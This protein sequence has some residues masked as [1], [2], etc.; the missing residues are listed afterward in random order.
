MT[1][2]DI[3]G[4]GTAFSKWLRLQPEIDSYL[5][6][7]NTNIDFYW[8]C[9]R[10]G[11]R[12]HIEEKT[13]KGHPRPHQYLSFAEHWWAFKKAYG[14][15]YKGFHIIRFENESPEDGWTELDGRIVTRDQL[16]IFLRFEAPDDWYI[17]N[18]K[19]RQA[20]QKALREK[21]AGYFKPAQT[22]KAIF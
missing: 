7:R 10:R 9:D 6:W 1:I 22:E 15:L 14:D 2:P 16:I 20:F 3:Y 21:G 17:T 19:V 5:G 13:R 8:R 18:E 12:M 11:Y 4:R